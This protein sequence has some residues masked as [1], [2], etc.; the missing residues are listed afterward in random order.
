MIPEFTLRP[1]NG[2]SWRCNW[3]IR[4]IRLAPSPVS[5]KN[6]RR[7]NERA[8]RLPARFA[9]PSR[10]DTVPTVKTEVAI[11]RSGLAEKF[12]ETLSSI[13]GHARQ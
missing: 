12:K 11:R 6:S 4:P 8:I 13:D 2:K 9:Y 7:A 5:G 3:R 1:N 10:V